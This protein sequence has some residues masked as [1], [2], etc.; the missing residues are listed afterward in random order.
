MERLRSYGIRH[1]RGFT[2]DVEI[3]TVSGEP[4]WMRLIAAPICEANRATR[5][6]GLKLMI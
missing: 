2:L 4:R 6:T 5:L 1:K 3:R